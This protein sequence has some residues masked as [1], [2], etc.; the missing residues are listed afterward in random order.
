MNS[1]LSTNLPKFGQIAIALLGF[2]AILL[3]IF[4]IA[5]RANGRKQRP[6]AILVFL[7]PAMILLLA[8]LIVPA[9][10]TILF[11]FK[12]ANSVKYV[13]FQNYSWISKNPDIH[14]VLF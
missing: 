8:G 9:V 2:F 12:D 6:I 4:Y 14:K 10:Q 11:S 13:G 1:F 3:A 7:G 5:G